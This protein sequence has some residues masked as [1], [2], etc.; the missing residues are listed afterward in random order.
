VGIY[1]KEATIRKEL[2]LLLVGHYA[3]PMDMIRRKKE[4]PSFVESNV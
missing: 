3:G 4:Y 1:E 2:L